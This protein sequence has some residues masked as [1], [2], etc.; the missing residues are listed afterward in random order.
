MNDGTPASAAESEVLLSAAEAAE[1]LRIS[2]TA[3]YRLARSGALR[4]HRFG[5]GTIRPRGLRIP[6]SAVSEF[7]RASEIGT[8]PAA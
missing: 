5:T 8:K 1:A 3:V 6:E 4:A 2:L 7:L